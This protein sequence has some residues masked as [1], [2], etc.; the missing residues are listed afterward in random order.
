MTEADI[1]G[2]LRQVLQAVAYCHARGVLHMDLKD[3]NIM[4]CDV[5]GAETN[6]MSVQP[7]LPLTKAQNVQNIVSKKT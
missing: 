1:R 2:V 7:S 6:L 3:Q 5:L 4:L